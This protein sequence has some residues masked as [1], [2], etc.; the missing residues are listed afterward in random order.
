MQPSIHGPR[1]EQGNLFYQATVDSLDRR[2]YFPA[3][4]HRPDTIRSFAKNANNNATVQSQSD[5]TWGVSR[6]TPSTRI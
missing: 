3:S 5:L 6:R 2:L 4:L 1:D